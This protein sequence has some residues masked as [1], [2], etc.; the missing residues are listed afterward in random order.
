[1]YFRDV[2]LQQYVD[3]SAVVVFDL[4]G[5]IIDDEPIQLE[6]TNEVLAEYGIKLA[7]K[8]WIAKCVGRRPVS[9]LPDIVPKMRENRLSVDNIIR[10]KDVAYEN[11]V[12]KV[13]KSIVRPGVYDFMNFLT[14]NN[15]IMSLATSTTKHGM[16]LILGSAGLDIIRRFAFIICGDEVRSGKPNPEIYN[17]VRQRFPDRR[18]AEFLVI[19]DSSVGVQAAK[20]ANMKCVAVPNTFTIGQDFSRADFVVGNLTPEANRERA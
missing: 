19:E 1:M 8:E 2:A 6:A 14:A 13:V 7:E 3:Q 15:K 17:R 4:N 20:N 5:L 9:W 12:I 11:R 16:D 18:E 10:A